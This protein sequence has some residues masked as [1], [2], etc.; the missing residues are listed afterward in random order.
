MMVACD[1][2][3]SYEINVFINMRPK[4]GDLIYIFSSSV[5]LFPTC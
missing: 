2:V 3:N 4:S 5:G 1:I